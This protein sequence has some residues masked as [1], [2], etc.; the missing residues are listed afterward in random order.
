LENGLLRCCQRRLN[1]QTS[2]STRTEYDERQS[3]KGAERSSKT[4]SGRT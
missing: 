3:L 1:Q 2:A 4:A